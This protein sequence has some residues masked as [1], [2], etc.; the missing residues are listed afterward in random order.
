MSD[1][2]FED[3]GERVNADAL[4]PREQVG[5]LPTGDG[6]GEREPVVFHFRPT[7]FI[8]VDDEH[9]GEWRKLF[10]EHADK[11]LDEVMSM[12][13]M[14]PRETISGSTPFGWDDCD[15]W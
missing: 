3:W 5:D 14:H 12:A 11:P 9:R 10:D 2:R 7:E 13:M 6:T 8:L 1:I 4:P 15:E